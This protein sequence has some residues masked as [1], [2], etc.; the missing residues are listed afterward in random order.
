[1]KRGNGSSLMGRSLRRIGWRGGVS[2][3]S[4]SSS[5]AKKATRAPS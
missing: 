3:M 1:M 2:M 5:R 4:S